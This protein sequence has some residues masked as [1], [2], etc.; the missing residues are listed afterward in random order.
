MKK[1]LVRM[2]PAMSIAFVLFASHAGGGFATGNQANTYFVKLGWSGLVS[3]VVAMVLLTWTLKEAIVMYNS[4]GLKS[5]KGLFETLYHPFDKLELVFEGFYYI[6]VVMVIASTISGSA[7]AIKEF[8]N[9][10]YGLSVL[11]VS[12]LTLM[13]AIFGERLVR[14]VGTLMG[15]VILVTSVL[16]YLVGSFKGDLVGVLTSNFAKTGFSN[17]D[18][19][20]F[21][22]FIYA[23]FQCVQ[24]PSMISCSRVLNSE[25][26]VSKSMKLSCLIN[27]LALGLSVLMLLVW[28]GYY[29]GLE[30]GEVIPTLT[31]TN[32]MGFKWMTAFYVI[33]LVLCLLSSGVS[34]I[35]GFVSRFENS[36]ALR[37][38][39]S[40][41]LRRFGLAVGILVLSMAISMAGLTNIIKY[42]Y[43]YCG[44]IAILFIVLPFTTVGYYKNKKYLQ[45]E[46]RREFVLD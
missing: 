39:E 6:M 12:V 36:K 25:R 34:I 9:F 21:N 5:Y 23:G 8:F 46:V 42:G 26:E 27:S 31:S 35:F 41:E 33:S 38:V 11:G 10:N 24:I 4:R 14:N 3:A 32:A 45:P 40:L 16:I 22:G 28:R 13:L 44:Y 20:I 18:K 7:S 37:K 1:K 2:S 29:T 43:G 15:M 19:A 30:G 17:L